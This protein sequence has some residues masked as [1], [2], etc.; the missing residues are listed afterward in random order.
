M[1][2][3]QG[4]VG[5]GTLNVGTQTVTL[6]DSDGPLLGNVSLGGGTLDYSGTGTLASGKAL[7]GAGLVTGA[8][9]SSGSITPTGAGIRMDGLLTGVGARVQASGTKLNFLSHGGFLGQ[10]VLACQIKGDA[11]SVITA[12]AASSSAAPSR[13]VS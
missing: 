3:P 8:V 7:S 13:A 6:L 11:G 5:Q 12:T 9:T 1:N 10:G 4:Y 2:D